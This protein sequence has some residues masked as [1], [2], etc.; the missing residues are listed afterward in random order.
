LE[1]VKRNLLQSINQYEKS[2][3]LMR[4]ETSNDD[5][6]EDSQPIQS[7][8]ILFDEA[9]ENAEDFIQQMKELERR[10]I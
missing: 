5:I 7:E 6:A 1:E 4:S 9:V 2:D 10:G 3:T 8:K